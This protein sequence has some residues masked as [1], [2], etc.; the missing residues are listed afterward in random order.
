VSVALGPPEPAVATEVEP[1][2]TGIGEQARSGLRYVGRNQ[3]LIVAFVLLGGLALSK[4]AFPFS[5]Y[6]RSA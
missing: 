1:P 3:Q 4:S 5:R 6:D 2:R